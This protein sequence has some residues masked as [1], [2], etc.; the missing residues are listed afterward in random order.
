MKQDVIVIGAGII[1]LATAERL[2]VQGAKVT[3]LERNKAGHESS[4]AG[5][6]YFIAALSMGLF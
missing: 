4:W 3:I 5:G 1:G 2:L 6:G